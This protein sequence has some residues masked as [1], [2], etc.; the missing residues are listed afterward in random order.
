M[1]EI[2]KISLPTSVTGLDDLLRGGFI[3]PSIEKGLILLVKGKPGTG[4]STLALQLAKGALSWQKLQC[5]KKVVIYSGEQSREDLK[6]LWMRLDPKDK[7]FNKLVINSKLEISSE[8]PFSEDS[9]TLEWASMVHD[10]ILKKSSKKNKMIIVDGLNLMSLEDRKTFQIEYLVK[11]LREQSLVGVIIFETDASSNDN[12]DYLADINIELKGGVLEGNPEYYLNHIRINKA[13][14]QS[15]VLGWHQYKITNHSGIIVYPSLHYRVHKPGRLDERLEDSEK[16][17]LGIKGQKT[18]AGSKENESSALVHLLGK[19]NL[20][21]GSCTIVLGARR[22]WKTLL[23][24]DFLRS[25]SQMGER[26]LLVSL[27]D[28]QPTIVNQREKLCYEFCLQGKNIKSI[29]KCPHRKCYK[30]VH[31]FHFRPGCIAPGEFLHYL[32]KSIEYHKEIEKDSIKRLVFWDLTQLEYRFPLLAQDKLFIPGLMD[33]LKHEH[34]ITSLFMGAPNMAIA[35]AAAAIA[36]NVIFCWQDI[37]KA[38]EI[39]GVAFYVDRIEG[40]P[41]SG[42]LY[43]KPEPSDKSKGKDKPKINEILQKREKKDFGTFK[44][45]EQ[46]REEIWAMQGLHVTSP[47]ST[48]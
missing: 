34:T 40:Q 5:H 28:N 48:I 11:A 9:W 39:N 3:T 42:D 1:K 27:I 15:H 43:F 17:I 7:R 4:K 47:K 8:I 29:K 36:D 6:S 33:L 20:K 2:N 26:G 35:R 21:P 18:P 30:K 38:G 45:A 32:T 19:N 41:E 22:T 13:R 24:F 10:D 25:G 12:L 16:N 14:F 37:A 23:T 46:M 44:Y 31:L